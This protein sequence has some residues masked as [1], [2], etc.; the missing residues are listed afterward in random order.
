[1]P[2]DWAPYTSLQDAAAVYLRDPDLALEQMR[3]VVEFPGIAAFI[4]SRGE[5]EEHWGTAV[6]QEVVA[7]DG[8]RLILWRA[9]DEFDDDRRQLTSSVRTILLSTISDHILS[10][11][12]D[13]LSDGTR[14]L[15]EVRLRMYT[16]LVTRA[17]RTS[18][19]D[20]DL[21]CE[22]FRYTKTVDNGGLAQMERL[23]QF[24]RVLSR[25]L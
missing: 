15:A 5:S 11:Q 2:Q 23:L 16:Q 13:V 3:S 24:G 25:S 9:D 22:S 1:M 6:W 12:F 7:T 8:L 17:R 14:R 19:T 4:M 10:T 20:S 21:Y 18:A